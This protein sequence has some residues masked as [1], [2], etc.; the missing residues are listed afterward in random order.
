MLI[1][2]ET[3]SDFDAVYTTVQAAFASAQHSDGTEQDLVTAL[4]SSAAFIPELSLVAA[5]DDKIVG[6]IMFT[7]AS[8]SSQT[9]LVLAPL[10]VLPAC[11]Q[12]GIGSALVQEGH[13]IA[14]ELGYKY[15]AVLGS[16]TY[17]PRFGYGPAAQLGI[18]VPA[19]IPAVNFMAMELLPAA[20]R[21][22]GAVQY[23]KEF[24]L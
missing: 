6:H 8:V 7:R 19:G 5:V 11:Q 21:L 13:R 9:I 12:R 18:E 16:E 3:S 24:V 23:A 22:C 2:Q 10:S 20:P 4:R 14:K 17:Y 15:I 1:R